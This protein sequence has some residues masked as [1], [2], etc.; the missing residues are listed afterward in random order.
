MV[1]KLKILE[2]LYLFKKKFSENEIFIVPKL[3][4]LENFEIQNQKNGNFRFFREK[5]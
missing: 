2:K 4:L 1:P 3:K 5:Y